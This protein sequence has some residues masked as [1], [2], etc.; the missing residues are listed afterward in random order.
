MFIFSLNKII[1]K[2]I[3]IILLFSFIILNMLIGIITVPYD[4]TDSY[5]SYDHIRMLEHFK[6]KIYP[7]PYNTSNHKI[8]FDNINALYIPS[9]IV[10][11][12]KNKNN[13][14]DELLKFINCCDIFLNLAIQSNNNGSIFPIWGTCLGMETLIKAIDNNIKLSKIYAYDN[15]LIPLKPTKEGMLH[16]EIIKNMKEDVLKEWMTNNVELHNHGLGITPS[17]FNK[18][19]LLSNM[20]YIVSIGNDK[21]NK[22]F[23]SLIE[24]RKYPFYGAQWHPEVSKKTWILFEVFLNKIQKKSSK[25]NLNILKGTIKDCKDY[26][27][28]LYK[29]CVFYKL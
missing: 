8:H 10:S 25:K 7:I 4:T 18:S 29:K 2:N 13:N 15:Y 11:K 3:I 26:S 24:G 6:L 14:K 28:N 23:V 1:I 19:K 17:Q 5:I 9:G 16:S 12:D 27:D 20:F 22:A 21:N